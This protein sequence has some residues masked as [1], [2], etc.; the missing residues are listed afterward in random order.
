[1]LHLKTESY[2]DF[3]I[4]PGICF[5]SI[6]FSGEGIKILFSIYSPSLKMQAEFA[7]VKEALHYCH[8]RLL[9]C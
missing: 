4:L 3:S 8:S 6:N 9:I 5:K 2:A 7:K 1:M